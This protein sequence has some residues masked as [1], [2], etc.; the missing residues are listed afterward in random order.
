M[1]GVVTAYMGWQEGQGRIY[2]IYQKVHSG[3]LCY[4]IWKSQAHSIKPFSFLKIPFF[5]ACIY[6]A[7]LCKAWVIGGGPKKRILAFQVREVD[8]SQVE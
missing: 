7:H 2:W 8:L 6:L 5:C 1:I 3:F 4:I